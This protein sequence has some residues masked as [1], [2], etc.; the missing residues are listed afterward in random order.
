MIQSEIRAAF[1]GAGYMASEHLK[2]FNALQ[3]VK[4]VGIHSRSL[5]R[6]E[7]LSSKYPG[8][9]VKHNIQ[10]LL[11]ETSPDLVIIS[12]PELSCLDVC[13]QAFQYPCTFLIE[14][15][16]GHQLAEAKAIEELST[17]SNLKT[18]VAFNRRF[19][20]STILLN[21]S[22]SSNDSPRLVTILDQ[23]DQSAALDAGQPK[24]V[25]DNWMYANSIHLIDF[26][27]QLCRGELN[28]TDVLIPWSPDLPGNVMAK[29][30]YSSG[31]VG[32]YQATW[33][34]PGPWSLSVNTTNFRAEMRP[35]EQL[36]IQHAGS[37]TSELQPTDPIDLQYKPGLFRQAQ[38]AVK[39]VLGKPHTLPTIV[40]AN[41]SMTLVSSIYF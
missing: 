19:Y 31:D 27:P 10:A 5:I 28:R 35:I 26:F 33:N 30:S 39:A 40:E 11:Q 9:A 25:V 18:Y 1:I 15:P 37:R 3:D 41:R 7:Q 17:S 12:V 8:L 20:S 23:E 32:L 24:Q 22:L 29:L 6:A 4:L 2:V 14:K 34:A 13:T 38:E 36:S 16:V 21:K